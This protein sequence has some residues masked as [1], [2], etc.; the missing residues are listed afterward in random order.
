MHLDEV[1]KNK[2]L[3]NGLIRRIVL[4][5]PFPQVQQINAYL[6][7]RK[8]FILIDTGIRNEESYN[9]LLSYLK[10]NNIAHL[11]AVYLTHGHV[12]HFG[13]AAQL[14]RQG[15][16][17]NIYIHE[18]EISNI[19]NEYDEIIYGVYLK[20]YGIPPDILDMMKYASVFFDTFAE[21]LDNLSFIEHGDSV[22]YEE[23][24][25]EVILT[26]GHTSGS[27]CFYEKEKGFMLSGDTLLSRLSPNPL[28]DLA[29]N[30][31]RR[32]SLIEYIS[33][34]DLLYNM[35]IKTVYPGHYE[36]IHD[37]KALIKN[38]LTFH[39]KRMMGIHNI[40]KQR[41]MT[42]YEI[43]EKLFKKLRQMDVFLAASEVIGHL[44]LLEQHDMVQS[45]EKDG[46]LY[47]TAV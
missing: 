12:D 9:M 30:G 38:L 35:D 21:R 18:R 17:E 25:F 34:L 44:D 32:K 5:L 28:L 37:H 36:I 6:V 14:R 41:P 45:F 2:V 33:S 43:T 47:Y 16:V 20:Q 22:E 39:Y 4:P 31:E 24:R 29:V 3:E 46:L 40:L 8:H 1:Q 26:P 11:D 27:V 13:A 19:N 7:G 10:A 15:I 42:P 23:G